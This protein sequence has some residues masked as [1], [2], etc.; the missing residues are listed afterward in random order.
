[1]PV[2]GMLYTAQNKN[3][4]FKKTFPQRK[5]FANFKLPTANL[6]N[7]PSKEILC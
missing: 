4:T 7:I 3:I 6:K 5:F 2:D 1:M